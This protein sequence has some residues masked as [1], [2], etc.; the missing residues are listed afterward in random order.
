MTEPAVFLAHLMADQGLDPLMQHLAFL[1]AP[2]MDEQGATLHVRLQDFHM[3]GGGSAHGGVIMTLLDVVMACS[4]FVSGRN[5]SCVTVEMKASFMRPGGVMGTLL[6]AQGF[7]RS[8]GRSLAFC[9]AEVRN[10]AGELLATAS[11]TFKYIDR[12]TSVV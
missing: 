12:P 6:H 7:L 2:Q 4:T 11:G 5:K 1:G 9:D 3:N 10:E 8:S